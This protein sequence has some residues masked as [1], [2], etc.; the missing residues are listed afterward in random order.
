MFTSITHYGDNNEEFITKRTDIVKTHS[1]NIKGETTIDD[2]PVKVDKK[3]ICW[4]L[5]L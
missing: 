2:H 1:S 4:D 3:D 5:L